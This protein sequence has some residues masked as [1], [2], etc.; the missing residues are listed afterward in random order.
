MT[1]ITATSPHS[2]LRRVLVLAI[3]AMLANLIAA[4]PN[5]VDTALVGQTGDAVALGGISVGAALATFVLWAF[6]FLRLGTAGFTARA[7]DAEDGDEIK[8]TLNR[9][10]TLAWV[11]GFVLLLVMVPIAFIAVPLFGSSEAV[12]DLAARYF[13]YRLFSAP[14]DLTNYV[15]LGWLVGLQRVGR[16][17][18]LQILLNGLNIILCYVLVFRFHLGVDGAAIATSLSQVVT[19]VAGIVV[20]RRLLRIVPLSEASGSLIDLDKLFVLVSVNFDLFLRTL[21][22][23]FV[24]VYFVGL[25]ARMGDSTLA[26]NQI[27]FALLAVVIQA[28]DGFTHSAEKLSGQAVAAHDREQLLA[29]TWGNLACTGATALMLSVLLYAVGPAIVACFSID[30]SVIERALPF[31]PWLA[32]M[33]L[34]AFSCYVLEGVFIGAARG[35]DM[36]NDIALAALGAIVAQFLLIPIFGNHG[37]WASLMLFFALR[38]V[39]L[40]FWYPRIPRALTP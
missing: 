1:D 14:F 25:G 6:A 17:L 12:A 21:A 31:L 20:A 27:L 34:V 32:A 10:L 5:L 18:A 29:S 36:R 26:A 39:P 30:P 2:T 28:F 33:P 23:M 19:A 13:H 3:P 40:A 4:L 9:A 37:L 15:I 16:A 8:A 38:A 11:F 24:L 7:F 22:T 35:R